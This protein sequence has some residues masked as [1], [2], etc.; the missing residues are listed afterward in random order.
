[1]PS[2][3]LLH[4]CRVSRSLRPQSASCSIL[5]LR[6]PYAC[7]YLI[8]AILN[9]FNLSSV[10]I[11]NCHAFYSLLY[12]NFFCL[13]LTDAA[14]TCLECPR[15]HMAVYKER[16]KSKHRFGLKWL[17][18]EMTRNHRNNRMN[19]LLASY[20]FVFWK[21]PIG[22]TSAKSKSWFVE[23]GEESRMWKWLP[24]G[25]GQHACSVKRF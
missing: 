25:L 14:P 18:A 8:L 2:L 21:W 17:W 6:S 22:T 1:M 7:F 9:Y 15:V 5:P 20:F 19:G 11:L 3:R 24:R 23:L 12:F 10:F 4:A 16:K 13:I